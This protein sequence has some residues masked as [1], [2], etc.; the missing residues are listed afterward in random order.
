MN[1]WCT[2][3]IEEE[4]NLGKRKKGRSTNCIDHRTNLIPVNSPHQMLGGGGRGF[5]VLKRTGR[6]LNIYTRRVHTTQ[7]R[8]YCFTT[9]TLEGQP[10]G[11][12]KAFQELDNLKKR[13]VQ[14]E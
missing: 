8:S 13:N 14:E 6:N 9:S 11:T 4:R 7:D 3:K 10:N 5:V 1:T 12:I 2:A